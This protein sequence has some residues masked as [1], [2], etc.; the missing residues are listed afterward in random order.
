MGGNA[1]SI[2]RSREEGSGLLTGALPAPLPA[3]I[4]QALS[5]SVWALHAV[6]FLDLDRFRYIK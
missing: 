5:N 6:Q 4:T 2:P 1:S 3:N